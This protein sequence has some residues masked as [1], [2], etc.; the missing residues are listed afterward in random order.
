MFSLTGMVRIV[1]ITFVSQ[2]VFTEKRL[3]EMSHGIVST[4]LDGGIILPHD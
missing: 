2:D 4:L 1:R 3:T